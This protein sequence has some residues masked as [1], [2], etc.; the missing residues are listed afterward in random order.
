MSSS[1]DPGGRHL[2]LVD[3]LPERGPRSIAD[4]AIAPLVEL[5]G[6]M[7]LL[8]ELAGIMQMRARGIERARIGRKRALLRFAST[9]IRSTAERITAA[10]D[11]CYDDGGEARSDLR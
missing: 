2:R 3:A 7:E 5:A 8:A 6:V 11:D 10:A 1:E 4:R 9:E